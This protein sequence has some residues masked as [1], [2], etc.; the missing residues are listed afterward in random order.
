MQSQADTKPAQGSRI[1]H[2]DFP[3]RPACFPFFYGWVLAFFATLG[4]CASMPGQTIGVGVFKTRL[5]EVL[6]LTSM[7]LSVSY[8]IGTFLSALFLGAGG[9]FFDRVGGRKALVYSVAAL[10]F[11][12]L[13]MSFVDRISLLAAYIPVVNF[14]IWLPGFICLALGFALL[15]FTGQGMV[16]LASRAILGKWFDRKRGLIIA[17]SGAVV[18]L[19][20][21]MAP[22]SFEYL[23]RDVGWQGAWQVMA[24]VLL[25]VMTALFWVFIRDNPE[26]CGLEMDGGASSKPRKMNPDAMVHR[27]FTR[28]EAARTF[29]FWAFTLMFALSGLVITAFTFHILAIGEEI[30]V[31]DDFILKLF[32]PGAAV[33]IVSGIAISWVTDLSFIRIK[34]LLCIMGISGALAYGCVGFGT[35]PEISWLH[36]LGFGVSGGCFSGLSIIIWPRFFGRQHLG[37]ISGLFMTTIVI[38]SAVGPFLFSMADSFLGNYRIAF[39]VSAFFAAALAVAALWADN[40]QRKLV[41]G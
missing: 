4:V 2:P 33:S 27:D 28:P 13:G 30:G 39:I 41:Q 21:S 26:E 23:I 17:V 9:K 32:V 15:R 8:M 12:L 35:Y 37:A 38:A 29:A 34:Y 40:P 16:T 20:F 31:S 6:G 1:W 36:V 19:T 22:L 10:G 25:L 7:Q 11:V 18:S 24:A 14:R 3:V 5:M